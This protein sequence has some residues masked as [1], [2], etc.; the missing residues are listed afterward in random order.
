MREIKFR[1]WHTKQKK[2]Y[3]AEE[4]ASDQLTLLPTGEFINVS[5]SSTKLSTI[6]PKDMFIPLQ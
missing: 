4:M 1:G 3:S 5:G 2:M 6:Y